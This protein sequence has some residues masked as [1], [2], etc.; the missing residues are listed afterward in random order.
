MAHSRRST[1]SVVIVALALALVAGGCGSSD[2]PASTAAG[3]LTALGQKLPADI[4]ERGVI[5]VGSDVAYAPVEFFEEGTQTV[6]GLD[7]D[8]CNAMAAKLGEGFT[9]RFMNTTFD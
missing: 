3:N 4:A 9:C 5:N 6:V 1:P 7:I 8:I 2:D